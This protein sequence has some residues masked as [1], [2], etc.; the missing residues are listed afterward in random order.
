MKH[1]TI[2]IDGPGG[3]GK[4]SVAANVAAKLGV[5]HLD[6][7]AMYR[8]FAWQALREGLNTKDAEGLADLARRIK[9]GVTF[10]AGA[11]HTF[12]NGQDVTALIRTPEI[13]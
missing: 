5:L 4:S 6:T 8:A 2:A 10:Q 9:I 3:A 11:Q 7:G 12:V 13:S 1:F